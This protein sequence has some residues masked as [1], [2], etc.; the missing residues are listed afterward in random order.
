MSK[1]KKKRLSIGKDMEKLQP[2]YITGG[3][4]KWYSL[5]SSLA[6]PQWLNIELAYNSQS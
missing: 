1:K 6:L 5:A 3:N 4:V 2:S